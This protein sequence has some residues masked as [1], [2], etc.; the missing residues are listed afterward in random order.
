M[1]R[2]PHK[3]CERQTLEL[4]LSLAASKLHVFSWVIM[5]DSMHS[6]AGPYWICTRHSEELRWPLVSKRSLIPRNVMRPAS[7]AKAL[8]RSDFERLEALVLENQTVLDEL[9]REC[10]I[11]TRRC[12]EIQCELDEL[13]KLLT[14][15]SATSSSP[16][17]PTS[18]NG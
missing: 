8:T 14:R 12:G 18:S 7:R 4:Y 5:A 13:K 16:T 6:D 17:N 15:P 9:R 11:Q 10:A 1:L 2:M 3:V